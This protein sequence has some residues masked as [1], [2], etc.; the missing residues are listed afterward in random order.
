M[1][2]SSSNLLTYVSTLLQNDDALKRFIVDPITDAEGKHCLTKAERAVLRRVVSGLSNKS[3][4][5]FSMERSLGSYRRSL[6]LLQNVLHNT[7]TKM[8]AHI[9]SNVSELAAAN[10]SPQVYHLVIN[11]PNISGSSADFTCKKNADVNAAGGPYANNQ[12]FQIVFDDTGAT[13]V[14]RLL[15]GASQ[16]FP[17]LISYQTVVGTGGQRYVKEITINGESITADLSNPCYDLGANPNADSVFWFFSV[18]GEP[19]TGQTG[20]VGGSFQDYQLQPGDTVYWQLIA[21]DASYGFQPCAPHTL[22]E[23][24][25]AK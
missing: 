2:H 1:L 18:N 5:G 7:G 6:R 10:T 3:V 19:G 4:N 12:G 24:A 25:L 16:A 17:S 14:E 11:Y 15:L 13:T 8:S 20:G 21:P 23:Y 9:H 22:N